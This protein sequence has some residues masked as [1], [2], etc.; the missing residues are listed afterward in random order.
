MNVGAEEARRRVEALPTQAWPPECY[1]C[2][3]R[4]LRQANMHACMLLLLLQ[5][6]QVWFPPHTR[7]LI[8]TSNS[9]PGVSGLSAYLHARGARSY[10]KTQDDTWIKAS[11]L[12]CNR[13][14][15]T[16]HPTESTPKLISPR[17][18]EA[19]A[20]RPLS[21]RPAWATQWVPGQSWG[22]Q[23]NPVSK[24]NKKVQ[25]FWKLEILQ[26][27]KQSGHIISEQD[28]VYLCRSIPFSDNN[29]DLM[30]ATE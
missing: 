13:I 8:T 27:A 2:S 14:I 12:T 25:L 20:G 9:S 23:R 24:R 29:G 22:A 3:P 30:D 21:S 16:E 26:K 28:I 18:R 11:L 5:R 19:E 6:A 17:A 1:P 4:T 7:K 15:H 10:R